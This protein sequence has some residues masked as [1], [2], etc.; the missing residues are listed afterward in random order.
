MVE[1]AIH[2]RLKISR[3]QGIEGSNPS[4]ATNFMNQIKIPQEEWFEIC[5]RLNEALRDSER[6]DFLLSIPNFSF[7]SR[8]EI[9]EARKNTKEG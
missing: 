1:L 6:L 5:I 4:A 3:P 7:G 2:W 9:D 8:F